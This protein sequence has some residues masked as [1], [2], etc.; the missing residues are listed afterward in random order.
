MKTPP[1]KLIPIACSDCNRECRVSPLTPG[2]WAKD[3]YLWGRCFVK[4]TYDE[5]LGST[6]PSGRS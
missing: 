2:I 3:S 6:E 4:H 1:E 5:P